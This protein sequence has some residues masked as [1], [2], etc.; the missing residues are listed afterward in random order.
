MLTPP[1]TNSRRCFASCE[2]SPYLE[3]RR[4]PVSES[5]SDKR[6]LL[7]GQSVNNQYLAAAV[8]NCIPIVIRVTLK[9]IGQ[10]NDKEAAVVV[11]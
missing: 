7:A 1:L 8:C 6:Q 2:L 3:I 10:D 9:K 5:G 11:A 4:A